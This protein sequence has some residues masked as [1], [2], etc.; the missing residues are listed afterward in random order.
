VSEAAA[1]LVCLSPGGI[2]EWVGKMAGNR[3]TA[4]SIVAMIRK[5]AAARV[6]LSPTGIR[7][8]HSA[9]FSAARSRSHFGSWRGA[10][11]AA[12][13][14][15]GGVK[16]CEQVWSRARV[17]RA[18]QRAADHGQD[19]LSGEF[20]RANKRLYSAAC[21]LRYFGGWRRAIEAAGLDYDQLRRD[22]F[23][24]RARIIAT[25]Q[26]M[27]RRNLPLNWSAIQRSDP[28]LYRAA[29]RRE[30]FGSWRAAVEAAG[31]DLR[32]PRGTKQWTR[33]RIVE[34]IRQMH[35]SG[36]DLSQRNVM[37]TNG[38]LLA[39]AKSSRYF[40]TWRAA[41]EAAGV[42]YDTVRRR[43]GRRPGGRSDSAPEGR[44]RTT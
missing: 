42:D 38:P 19:L 11:E 17:V 39:A 26:D 36:V 31:M 23:W 20:K 13:L 7:E 5:L 22:H 10:V 28:S 15:Y 12:G 4:D 27:H 35:S 33:Q 18:I 9:L 44:P 40:G 21:A 37:Q 2:V 16:R 8:S 30:N 3:W 43:R 24:S 41:V 6:D 29:R 1:T 25:I 32:R 14:D 34:E